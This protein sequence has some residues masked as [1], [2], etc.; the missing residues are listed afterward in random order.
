M[1]A[2]VMTYNEWYGE[3]TVALNR[4][5]KRY[6]VSPCDYD[7]LCDEFG[8]GNHDAILKAVKERSTSGMYQM[9][10]SYTSW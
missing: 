5:L 4:A 1:P 6:N 2:P 8:R 7:M 10:R 9:R 3:L